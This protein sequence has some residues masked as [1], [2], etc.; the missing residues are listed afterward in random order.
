MAKERRDRA[1]LDAR[2]WPLVKRLWRDWVRGHWR[3]IVLS[4]T[5]MAVIAAATGAY[6]LVIDYAYKLFEARDPAIITV[7]LPLVLLVTMVKGGATYAQTVLVGAI[8]F[9]IIA[10]IQK[11]MFAHLTAADLA[12]LGREPTGALISRFTNDTN[13]LRDAMTR[14]A[15]GLVRD[16]LTV[17]AL[18]G[19][20]VYLDWA[21]TLI[22][23]VVY[24]LAALPVIAIGR[25]LR[26]TSAD[27]QAHLGR[28][29]AFLGES[30][31]GARMVKTYGLEGYERARASGVFESLYR[32]TMRLVRGR[33]AVDPLLEVLGGLAIGGVIAFAGWRMATGAAD[34]GTFTG[35]ISALL[36]AA[37][38]VRAIATLNVVVQEGLAAVVRLYALMDEPPSIVDRAG[39]APLAVRQGEIRFEGVRF[40]YGRGAGAAAEG[41]AAGVAGDGPVD[42]LDA[43]DLVFEPGVT[44]A[45][46]GPSGAGKSTVL[47]LIPRLYDV[48]AG[49]VLIDGQDLRAVTLA[50]LRASMALVSQD[51]VLFDD[52]VRANIAFG[53][54]DATDAEIRAAAEAA[55]AAAFIEALPDGYDTRVGDRGLT[56]SGGERQRLALARAVLRDAPILLLDEA[57]SA[58]DAESERKVQAALERLSAGRTTI[59]IAHRLAT[60]RNAARLYVLDRGGVA[61]QGAHDDLVAADG[62][63][64]RLCRMQVFAA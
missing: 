33:A 27:T 44:T 55:A 63:Y 35:F 11:A 16:V 39:A 22:V 10:N 25:R 53:R 50:S 21:L 60:V 24:P 51:V 49:R 52:T 47:N 5:L 56:L 28:T 32:F 1:A 9:R 6:P 37:Q 54:L 36:I 31:A 29:T 64:A 18:V 46:V 17:A 38:P 13:V 40:T 3:R 7:I 4:L 12:R 59:V 45:L 42:A 19:A 8:V 15:T 57:T 2:T 20:M 26:G 23:L 43:V 61:E 62:L 34:V 30:L 58:L 48:T 14:V 41:D